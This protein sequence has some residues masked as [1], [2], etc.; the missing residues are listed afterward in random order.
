MTK[1]QSGVSAQSLL[2]HLDD[3]LTRG[4]VPASIFGNAELFQRELHEIFSRAWVFLAHESEIA[5]N[6]DY[7]VRKIGQDNFIVSRGEDGAI[8]VLLDACRHRGVAV[9]RAESGNASHFRCP[10]HGWTYNSAGEMT[11]APLWRSALAGVDKTANNLLRAAQV[12]TYQGLIFATLDASAPALKDYLGGMSWYLDTIFGLNE[13]GVELLG[14]PQRFVFDANWKSAAENF[15]GD[16]YHVGTLH[17]TVFAVGAFPVPFAQNMMGYHIQAGPGHSLSLS[18]AEGED[19]PGPNFL[20]YPDNLAAS[21]N[22]TCISEEQLRIAKRTRV[23]VGNVFPNFSILGAPLTEDGQRY[24]PTGVLTIRC[25]QP[26][27][28]NSV[29]LW[30]WFCTYKNATAEQKERAYKAGLGTFSMGGIFEM[31]DS[32]P[33]ISAARTG[34]SVAAEV[35]G[36]DLNY[37]MGLDGIGEAKQVA[38]FPGPGVVFSPR[39]EEGVQ[40][41]F[42]RFYADLMKAPEGKWPDTVAGH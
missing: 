37:Q 22:T 5:A 32:E 4:T 6:G 20:G 9:C 2:D 35:L 19:D 14:P 21:F 34:S 36:L 11:G 15:A 38:D 18:M 28:P 40:R 24:A 1:A 31:D 12:D 27:G 8:N 42:Y 25:W 30:N 3:G 17:R 29:E 23:F 7:V 13:H 10:Y 26:V 41:N 39:H 16:D 33:W